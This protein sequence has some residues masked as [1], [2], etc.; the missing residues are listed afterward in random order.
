MCVYPHPP[1]NEQMPHS[2]SSGYLSLHLEEHHT[3]S[4]TSTTQRQLTDTLPRLVHH[5]HRGSKSQ[6]QVEKQLEIGGSPEKEYGVDNTTQRQ[7][8]HEVG[9]METEL[10]ITLQQQPGHVG[11]CNEHVYHEPVGQM[12]VV[13]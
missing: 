8:P 6:R 10:Y 7:R 9:D 11:G 3:D 2:V 13:V 12:E 5:E 4:I 1:S